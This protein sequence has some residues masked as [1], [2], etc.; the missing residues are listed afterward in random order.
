M[1]KFDPKLFIREV[2][3]HTRYLRAQ[4]LLRE[5]LEGKDRLFPTVWYEDNVYTTLLNWEEIRSVS[6][7]S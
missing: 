1:T 2:K 6:R 5:K 4:R 7:S 3:A